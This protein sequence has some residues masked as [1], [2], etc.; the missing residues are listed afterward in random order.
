M[1][2]IECKRVGVELNDR[3]FTQHAQGF[4]F[5]PKNQQKWGQGY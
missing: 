1:S 5:H 2:T 3:A 4:R